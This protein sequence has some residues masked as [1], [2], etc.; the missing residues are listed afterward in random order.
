MGEETTAW[1]LTRSTDF[2]ADDFRLQ[3]G[4]VL[5]QPRQPTTALFTR[6]SGIPIAENQESSTTSLKDVNIGLNSELGRSFGIWSS[7][8]VLPAEAAIQAAEQQQTSWEWRFKNL[9]TTGTSFDLRHVKS[10]LEQSAISDHIKSTYRSTFGIAP[11][12]YIVTGLRIAEGAKMQ[13]SKTMS[14]EGEIKMG[15]DLSQANVPGKVKLR[16]A[17]RRLDA[18]HVAFKQA[19]SF[20]FAYQ[21]SKIN[22]TFKV[23]IAPFRYGDT[24]SAGDGGADDYPEFVVDGLK[25]RKGKEREPVS[26]REFGLQENDLSEDEAFSHPDQPDVNYCFDVE[27][28]TTS[29]LEVGLSY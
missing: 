9:R 2:A 10:L 23:R 18:S 12:L 1:I 21:C 27:E 8:S 29:A 24:Q 20:I 28:G 22:S 25:V 19:S 3:L 5:T 14:T 17:T 4:Q 6:S 13:M 15:I 11:E 16:A 7:V 26:R